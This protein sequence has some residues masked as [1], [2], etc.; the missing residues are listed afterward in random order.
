MLDILIYKEGSGDVVDVKVGI[1]FTS[2]QS[3]FEQRGRGQA[4]GAIDVVVD[5]A[6]HMHRTSIIYILIPSLA[7][8]SYGFPEGS[9]GPVASPHDRQ[10]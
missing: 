7:V 8:M 9:P 3:R 5:F 4:S 1:R 6:Y 10:E 2:P